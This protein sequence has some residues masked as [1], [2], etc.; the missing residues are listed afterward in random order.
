MSARRL[1]PVGADGVLVECADAAEAAALARWVAETA[2][3]PPRELVPA[4]ATVLAVAAPGG[5]AALTARLAE[6]PGAAVLAARA[7][8][9]V[10][11]LVIPV[12]YDGED[13]AGVA[14][15]LGM[16]VERL[17]REH[18]AAPWLIDFLGF[19]PGFGYCSRPDWPHRVPRLDTP[20]ARVPAGAVALAEGWSGVYP[21]ASPGGWRIVGST[22]AALWDEARVPPST[23]AAGGTVRYVEVGGG[24]S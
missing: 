11:E 8:G 14:A 20:R 1:R 24:A 3:P 6:A 16:S 21:R 12:R 10:P 17:V 2:D 9:A 18:T 22:D 19:A 7:A 23:L 15:G 13:L 4:A 5:L